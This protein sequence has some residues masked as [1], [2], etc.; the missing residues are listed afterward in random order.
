V[1]ADWGVLHRMHTGATLQIQLNRPCV[2]AMQ[3]YVKLLG[4]L[5]KTVAASQN[6]SLPHEQTYHTDYNFIL[7]NF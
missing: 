5:A 7:L 3:P 1:D 2:A 6:K 4:L